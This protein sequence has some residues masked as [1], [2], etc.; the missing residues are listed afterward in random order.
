MADRLADVLQGYQ[1]A[2]LQQMARFNGLPIEDAMGHLLN[3]PA[4]IRALAEQLFTPQRVYASLRDLGHLERAVLHRAVLKGAELDTAEFRAQLHQ[5]N[6]VSPGTPWIKGRAFEGDAFRPSSNTFEDVVARLTLRGLLLSSG[7][8]ESWPQRK[9]LSLSPGTTLIVPPTVRDC[10]PEPMQRHVEWGR[11]SLPAPVQEG[12]I[13]LSQRDLFI[14]W[15]AAL[16]RRLPLTQAGFVRKRALRQVNDQLLLPDPTLDG[17]QRESQ[18]PRLYFLRLLLQDLDLLVQRNLHLEASLRSGPAARFWEETA[19]QRAARALE[20]WEEMET[21][22]ELSGLGLASLD[23]DLLRA[24]RKLVEQ[25]AALEVGLW[26]SSERFSDRL[27]LAAPNLLIEPHSL[28]PW[29]AILRSDDEYANR[30]RRR[31]AD[32]QATFL[33]RALSGPLHWLGI[34]DISL[35]DDRLLAFRVTEQGSKVLQTVSPNVQKEPPASSASPQAQDVGRV[36]VQPSLHVLALGPVPESVLAQ[37]EVFADRVQADRSA[38]DY[39]LSRDT[40][41]RGQQWGLSGENIIAS[42]TDMSSVPIPENVQRSLRDWDRQYQRIT[43]FR[44]VAL[45][46]TDSPEQLDE[47]SGDMAVR[48]HLGH[49]LAPTVAT[50]KA[51]HRTGLYDSL[52]DR[53][54]LAAQS[55]PGTACI[56]QVRAEPSG[57]LLRLYSGP[58]LILEKC[59]AELSEFKDSR[60]MI[61][62]ESVTR[63]LQRGMTLPQYLQRLARLNHGPLP[64]ELQARIKAWG[65]YYGKA[66]LLRATLLEVKDG[67]TAEELL[68]DPELASLLSRFAPDPSGRHLLVQSDDLDR[69][70]QLLTERGVD[71]Q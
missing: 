46:Q 26:I 28:G 23:L 21:W 33:G 17:A 69:V 27:L 55:R 58:D 3:K 30:H 12:D 65:H 15:S 19:Q 56:G 54:T 7:I 2:A 45:L 41:Y 34:V 47:L 1:F 67:A 68:A 59:L 36:I 64:A 6:V 13:A 66:T 35:D 4:L 63:A 42:L 62:Q 70:R 11:G 8:P 9:M 48:R 5:E 24:R 37:L 44:R 51:G 20:A 29:A 71:L 40:V 32:I 16:F 50:I 61:T 52:S 39:V 53:G 43:V 60:H 38:F 14:Y 18:S 31:I 22:N 49:R 57:E 10:L 25:L